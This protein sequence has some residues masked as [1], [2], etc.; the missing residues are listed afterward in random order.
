M[1][2]TKAEGRPIPVGTPCAVKVRGSKKIDRLEV[3]CGSE[4]LYDS[5][6]V[7]GLRMGRESV[8]RRPGGGDPTDVAFKD[9]GARELGAEID[10]NTRLGQGAVWQEHSRAFRVE[11]GP[12]RGRRP[13]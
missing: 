12:A 3:V 6:S 2:V 7:G 1:T 4:R 9:V 8:F 5:R 10:I 13:E 11:L